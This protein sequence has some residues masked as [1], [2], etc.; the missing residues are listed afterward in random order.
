M[1]TT[2]VIRVDGLRELDDRLKQLPERLA[3]GIVAGG[4]RAGAR[5]ILRQAKINAN[6]IAKTR[7]LERSIV[8]AR[9]RRSK[10]TMPM[11][12]IYTRRGT[13]YQMGNR[14]GR[15][16]TNRRANRYNMDAFYAGFVEYGTR[17]HIIRA[18]PGKTL[19]FM[20]ASGDMAFRRSVRHPGADAKPFLGPAYQ[21]K[22]VEALEAT[23]KFIKDRLDQAAGTP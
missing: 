12:S 15:Q 19:K 13:S 5:V 4:L 23:K 9:D 20:G 10:P 17:P 7:T 2:E 14:R 18:S 22:K 3:K 1:A 11:Y 21:S 8:L 16:G 6:A